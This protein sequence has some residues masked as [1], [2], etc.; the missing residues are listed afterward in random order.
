[1]VDP[2]TA[3]MNELRQW[4]GQVIKHNPNSGR[5][6][7]LITCLR[8]PDTPSERPDMTSEERNV[9]YSGRRRRKADT[10]EVI[11][12]KAFGGVVGGSARYRTDRDFVL[13]PPEGEWDH[14][15]KHVQ[16]AANAIGIEVKIKEPSKEDKPA[17]EVKLNSATPLPPV[18][19]AKPGKPGFT[20]TKYPDYG[21]GSYFLDAEK[22]IKTSPKKPTLAELQAS[23]S[24]K[25]KKLAY[26]EE[27][28][29]A[30]P[31]YTPYLHTIAAY[32][33][34]IEKVKEQMKGLVD[35][36]GQPP[37]VAQQT[38]PSLIGTTEMFKV[39]NSLLQSDGG[40]PLY[41]LDIET[42]S[43]GLTDDDIPF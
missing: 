12:A 37:I 7:D 21:P 36:N 10:V 40:G 17:W 8:G 5:F 25:E 4:M 29:M 20:I 26:Y 39:Y 15:D 41:S 23:L 27:K 43:K 22:F 19:K 38:G 9:A 33:A 16:R 2:K 3:S 35:Q 18:M 24:S 6:W 28:L 14:F 1:M 42:P 34:G 13:L 30:K 11:R 32:K 31:G